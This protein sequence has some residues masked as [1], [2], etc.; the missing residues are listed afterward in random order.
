[1][2][3]II[4]HCL[5]NRNERWAWLASHSGQ[6]TQAKVYFLSNKFV[7]GTKF[8]NKQEFME[9]WN[10]NLLYIGIITKSVLGMRF[11]GIIFD[12]EEAM[13]EKQSQMI[14]P[15]IRGR[16]SGSSL[17]DY[18]LIHIG[19]RELRT[20]FNENTKRFPTSIVS[21]TDCPWLANSRFVRDEIKKMAEWEVNL[22]YN[23][24]EDT[25]HGLVFAKNLQFVSKD[26]IVQY[27]P[28]HAGI[29]INAN[30]AVVK[31]HRNGKLIVIGQEYTTDFIHN[32][33]SLDELKGLSSE[34]EDGGYN[35][36][37]AEL[38]AMRI[39][40]RKQKWDNEMK[41]IRQAKARECTILLCKELTPNIAKDLE[42]T[43]YDPSTGLYYKHP[44]KNPC[45]WLDAFLHALHESFS[46]APRWIE[47]DS[48]LTW[49]DLDR[50]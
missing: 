18:H 37:E 32:L 38:I 33:S 41:S 13:D 4:L 19:T 43:P 14:Y 25:P 45:H 6:L 42:N 22:Y 30:E 3:W 26:E 47:H 21:W 7:K 44:T 29:D 20:V 8:I 35:E 31:I 9:L 46:F 50:R 34:V 15:M 49:D 1:M 23:C 12:E 40:A 39:G 2:D 5:R 36:K 28:S 27:L 24:L 10:G 11:K 17:H 16:L 48:Q